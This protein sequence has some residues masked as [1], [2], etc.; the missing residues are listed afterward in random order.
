VPL[1][2]RLSVRVLPPLA[3][4]AAPQDCARTDRAGKDNMSE[5]TTTRTALIHQAIDTMVQDCDMR[6][7]DL[8]TIRFELDYLAAHD[9]PV[10]DLV[11]ELVGELNHHYGGF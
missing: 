3:A 4:A 9:V 2:S 10:A 6:G 8:K 1:P 7:P 5:T 11:A